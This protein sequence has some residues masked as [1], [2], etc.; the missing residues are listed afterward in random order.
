MSKFAHTTDLRPDFDNLNGAQTLTSFFV[1]VREAG[2]WGTTLDPRNQLWLAA[3]YG[4]FKDINK[5]GVFDSADTWSDPAQGSVQG[6]PVPRNYFAAN[7]PEKLVDGLQRAFREIVGQTGSGAGVGVAAS[8]LSQTTGENGIYQVK[9]D[10]TDWTGS[11]SGF[12]I[13]NIDETT[14]AIALNAAAF[15]SGGLLVAP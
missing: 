3:K 13:F 11:V 10:T 2:S 6:F 15:E 4:G 12:T 5:N 14:G 1:D 9:F 8:N 7:Q